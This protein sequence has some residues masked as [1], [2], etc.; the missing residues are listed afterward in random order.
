MPNINKSA[1][2]RF[3]ITASNLTKQ[4][5][6]RSSRLGHA[7]DGSAV[8]LRRDASAVER[9]QDGGRSGL[10]SCFSITGVLHPVQMRVEA[11]EDGN[12]TA[13]EGGR[14]GRKEERNVHVDEGFDSEDIGDENHLVTLVG[15]DLTGFDEEVTG[16]DF[17]GEGT[18][19]ERRKWGERV[20]SASGLLRGLEEDGHSRHS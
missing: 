2:E 5:G 8:G 10:Y 14:W 16:V 11:L 18:N 9:T 13:E 6:V 12:L 3:S 15:R 17:E 19:S 7:D 20:R 1:H 4:V